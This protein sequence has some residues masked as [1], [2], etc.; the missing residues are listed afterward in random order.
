MTAT[1]DHLHKKARKLAEGALGS[2]EDLVAVIP[3]R[4]KQA[5]IVS[6]RRILMVK[7][8]ILSGAWLGPKVASFAL[9]AITT[10]NVH[11]GRGMGALELVIAGRPSD[12]KADVTTAFQAANWLPC[13]PSVS[14]SPLIGELRAYVQSDG[15]S[16][17][18]RA[19][20][21]AFDGGAASAR[22]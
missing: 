10:I 17:S 18:A 8:G 9:P 5:M 7:P 21:G 22:P 20:L 6:D 1:I 16:R 13:H 4:S 14:S 12:G 19:Q 2:D 3:G 11:A 15:E